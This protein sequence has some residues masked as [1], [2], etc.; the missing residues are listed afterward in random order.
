[1]RT[2]GHNFLRTLA[3]MVLLSFI[4]VTISGCAT[5]VK[6][7]GRQKISFKSSP[8]AASLKVYDDSGFLVIDG[9]TPYTAVLKCGKGY[10]KS[11]KYKVSIEKN[12]YETKE[13]N[14]E[15]DLSGWYLAGNFIFG[16]LIGYLIID[17]LSGA[18]WTLSPK[19]VYGILPVKVSSV[20]KQEGLL[21][22]LKKKEEIPA[23]IAN[24]M[25]P[26]IPGSM[27]Q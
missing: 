8:S 21:I 7:G 26:V 24:K 12:G 23:E 2:K 5:I 15:G 10:F 16:G 11:A 17:P 4:T 3:A 14:I 19:E 22:V 18:M 6:G 9:A 1:M 13:F 25:K 27:V 20:E